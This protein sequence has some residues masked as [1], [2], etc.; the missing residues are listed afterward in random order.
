MILIADSG[1]TKTEWREVKDG[2]AGR[3]YISTGINPFFVTGDEII[4]L[5]GKEL[6][7]LKDAG[8]KRIFFYGTGVSNASKAEIVRGGSCF[9]FRYGRALYRQ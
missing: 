7:E 3:S 8:V 5:F 2:R 9:L 4:R 1:S 6:P